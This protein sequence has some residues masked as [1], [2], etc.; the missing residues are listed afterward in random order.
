MIVNIP[1]A[2]VETVEQGVVQSRHAAGVGKIDRQ[3]PVMN[4]KIT[5][6]NFNP[7]W[8]VP[9]SIIRKDLIPKMQGS[10][11]TSRTTRS[12][13]SPGGREIRPRR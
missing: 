12:A 7:F 6:V 13:S 4:A 10:G 5:E 9:A 2:L 8:T 1:A 3:S 11:T